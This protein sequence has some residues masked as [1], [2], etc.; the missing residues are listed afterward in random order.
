MHPDMIHAVPGIFAPDFI[1]FMKIHKDITDMKT[2]NVSYSVAI[3][4][5]GGV[6]DYT[7][8]TM[9]F[10]SC[11]EIFGSTNQKSIQINSSEQYGVV[12]STVASQ[13][14]G[15]GFKSKTFCCGVYMFS[16][17]SSG[18]HFPAQSKSMHAFAESLSPPVSITVYKNTAIKS[19]SPINQS[20]NL[21]YVFLS[22]TDRTINKVIS[23]VNL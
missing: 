11:T 15:L 18:Y 21:M 17:C 20:L 5:L 12:I 9:L 16:L 8:H 6:N 10:C 13:E 1:A 19:A 23:K 2:L 3:Y 22:L 7:I 14:E 4:A